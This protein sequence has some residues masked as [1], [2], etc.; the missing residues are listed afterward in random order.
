L[1]KFGKHLFIFLLLGLFCIP[2]AA[3][4]FWGNGLT[5][6]MRQLA[7]TLSKNETVAVSYIVERNSGDITQ[8]GNHWRSLIEKALTEANVTVKARKDIVLIIDDL[9]TFGPASDEED[10]WRQAGADVIISGD[11]FI[12]TESG[13]TGKK[14]IAELTVK[15]LRL[16][17]ATVLKTISIRQPLKP[18]WQKEAAAI[19]GNIYQRRIAQAAPEN[20]T[21]PKLQA[22]LNTKRCYTPGENAAITVQTEPGAHIY[23]LNLA[24]DNSVSML[25]PNALLDDQPLTTGKLTFPPTALAKKLTLAIYPLK[26]GETSQEAIKV[27]SSRQPLDFSFLPVPKNKIYTGAAGGDLQSVAAALSRQKGWSQIILRYWVGD[28]CR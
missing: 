20:G 5:A 2:A 24:A 6:E 27:I 17:S 28:A 22:A 7:K 26:K 11:Y 10:I 16:Q 13:I 14:D 21:G 1:I 8:L 9:E 19:V 23:I 3:H 25:Y 18:G 12:R 4:A 15:A